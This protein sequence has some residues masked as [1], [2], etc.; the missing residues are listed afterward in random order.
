MIYVL[1]DFVSPSG[2]DPIENNMDVGDGIYCDQAW[3][4]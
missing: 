3:Q 2:A 4:I 1:D